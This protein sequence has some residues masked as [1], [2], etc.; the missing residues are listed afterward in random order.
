L[1]IFFERFFSQKKKWALQLTHK[2]LEALSLKWS[3]YWKRS[4]SAK[5]KS[6]LSTA[7]S[8]CNFF[9]FEFRLFSK[10]KQ[11]TKWN[12]HSI[13]YESYMNWSQFWQMFFKNT[14]ICCLE[15]RK[16]NKMGDLTFNSTV[17][18]LIIFIFGRK[19]SCIENC[20]KDSTI[21]T[22]VHQNSRV[23]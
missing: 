14:E 6:H 8:L 11:K 18:R 16:N 9:E 4:S 5:L 20:K 13:F 3:H 15:N 22:C 1:K 10:I 2:S 12:Q 7:Q 23:S 17:V 21:I 19:I